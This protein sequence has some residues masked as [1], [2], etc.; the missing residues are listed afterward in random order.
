[1]IIAREA[2]DRLG[3]DF[4]DV[5]SGHRLPPMLQVEI[6]WMPRPDWRAMGTDRM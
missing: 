2:P 3:V 1:M 4:P 6:R 5:A